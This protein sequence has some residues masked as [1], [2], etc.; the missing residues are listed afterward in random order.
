LLVLAAFAAGKPRFTANAYLQPRNPNVDPTM[1]AKGRRY[2]I[3]LHISIVA[4]TFF[5]FFKFEDTPF[6]P[7]AKAQILYDVIFFGIAIDLLG[8]LNDRKWLIGLTWV[9]LFAV[10][11]YN[12]HD[13][14]GQDSSLLTR[15]QHVWANVIIG[16]TI[17]AF[18]IGIFFPRKTPARI[19]L[20]S[21]AVIGFIPDIASFFEFAL[22]DSKLDALLSNPSTIA[23][24]SILLNI[25]LALAVWRTPELRK[26]QYAD[27]LE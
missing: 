4:R 27:F 8:T 22:N 24:V 20:R 5:Y 17:M 2:F 6:E 10:I 19:F 11:A 3:L 25:L 14:I 18:Y 15:R 26:P 1:N 13:W 21:I 12:I 9:T 16:V 23:I 7:I